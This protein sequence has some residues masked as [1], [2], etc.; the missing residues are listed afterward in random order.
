MFAG[1]RFG[2]AMRDRQ[3]LGV[4]VLLQ[5]GQ[6]PP[7]TR[8]SC[9]LGLCRHLGVHVPVGRREDPFFAEEPLLQVGG[10]LIAC[11]GLAAPLARASSSTCFCIV[12][13]QGDGLLL[14]FGIGGQLAPAV[15]ARGV[16]LGPDTSTQ[17]SETAGIEL[18]LLRLIAAPTISDSCRLAHLILPRGG[19]IVERCRSALL[20]GQP[21]RS[22]PAC[23]SLI[24]SPTLLIFCLMGREYASP[25][26]SR[27]A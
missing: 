19:E 8:F 11:R 16:R 17:R 5:L 12:C 27:P 4:V 18:L 9:S 7:L 20:L 10:P 24:S 23:R 1:G 6:L 25:A 21:G 3:R 15:E 14:L 2:Q 13:G 26:P 22:R